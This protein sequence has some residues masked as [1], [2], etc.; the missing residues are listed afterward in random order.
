MP[1]AAQGI[2]SLGLSSRR[3]SVDAARISTDEQGW[4]FR[5]EAEPRA[6]QSSTEIRSRSET[7]GT[8][9]LSPDI[10][11]LHPSP[12][13]VRRKAFTNVGPE[14]ARLEAV[15]PS[16]NGQRESEQALRSG[17]QILL[18]RSYSNA[19]SAAAAAK[20]NDA[21]FWFTKAKAVYSCRPFSPKK[22]QGAPS[23]PKQPSRRSASVA[24]IW[25]VTEIGAGFLQKQNVFLGQLRSDAAEDSVG[26]DGS[27]R[28]GEGS[29]V[30]AGGSH[31]EESSGKLDSAGCS[32]EQLISEESDHSAAN[33]APDQNGYSVHRNGNQ[34]EHARR[35]ESA[36]SPVLTRIQ[37]GRSASTSSP[38][39]PPSS[40]ARYLPRRSKS[41]TDADISPACGPK[42]GIR[43]GVSLL[44]DL[45]Q[46]GLY[47][48]TLE[49]P[50]HGS[51]SHL[52]H[53]KSLTLLTLLGGESEDEQRG[54]RPGRRRTWSELQ[55]QQQS[56]KGRS[57]E[58]LPPSSPLGRSKSKTGKRLIMGKFG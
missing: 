40:P 4:D 44:E 18:K 58:V 2:M 23:K 28:V 5:H 21:K 13:K 55:L 39:P 42:P 46:G 49:P 48:S 26:E 34:A 27:A 16:L 51:A 43:D 38:S 7:P 1:L 8:S 20:P 19:S 45:P 56:Q 54:C 57:S 25:P 33:A 14:I 50:R 22:K 3:R 32:S 12:S 35:Y 17:Q 47:E 52:R 30:S 41:V 10:R 36:E 29:A 24:S 15:V 37:S 6:I 11:S 53:A 9:Q 31:E